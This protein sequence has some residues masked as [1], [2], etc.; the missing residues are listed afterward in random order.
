MGLTESL[1]PL[2]TVRSAQTPVTRAFPLSGVSHD[3][4]RR[5]KPEFLLRLEMHRTTG[6]P[7]KWRAPFVQGFV[8]ASL[9]GMV[10]TSGRITA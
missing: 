1:F 3:R 5:H 9:E 8:S 2:A 10:V 7:K 4:V 6:K